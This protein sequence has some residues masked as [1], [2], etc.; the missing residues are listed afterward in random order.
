MT[1][2]EHLSDGLCLPRQQPCVQ[3]KFNHTKKRAR[4]SK[5]YPMRWRLASIHDNPPPVPHRRCARRA[6]ASAQ[7]R[8]RGSTTLSRCHFFSSRG[9][10]HVLT[11]TKTVFIKRVGPTRKQQGSNIWV[12][13]RSLR[14]KINIDSTQDHISLKWV[15]W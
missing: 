15:C 10:H 1:W 12:Y 3:F 14:P 11:T 6:R 9:A 2:R 5:V 4:G 13:W 8:S 7:P